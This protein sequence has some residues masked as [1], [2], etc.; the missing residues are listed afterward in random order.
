MRAYSVTKPFDMRELLARIA[1][2]LRSA[3]QRGASPVLAFGGITLHIDTRQ[4]YVG[5]TPVKL[6]RTEYAILKLL[7]QNPS[8]AVTKSSLLERISADTPP[9]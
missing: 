9:V 2:Q 7:M 5:E 1:V 4:A 3:E 8:Q 6:T